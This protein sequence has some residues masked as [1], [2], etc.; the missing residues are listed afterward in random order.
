MR[1]LRT[2]ENTKPTEQRAFK[3]SLKHTDKFT[4]DSVEDALNA[5]QIIVKSSL[6]DAFK[7][8]VELQTD[9]QMMIAEMSIEASNDGILTEQDINKLLMPLALKLQHLHEDYLFTEIEGYSPIRAVN[10]QGKLKP[11]LDHKILI[12]WLET[13]NGLI[14]RSRHELKRL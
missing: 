4:K 5:I 9:I 10:G 8:S 13:F 12:G 14:E 3:R 11:T 2:L 7:C 6:E 1:K